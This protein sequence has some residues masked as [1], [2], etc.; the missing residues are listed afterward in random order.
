M[1]FGRNW[2]KKDSAN[3]QYTPSEV[4]TVGT[5]LSGQG[6]SMSRKTGGSK[7]GTS[8]HGNSTM[9]ILENAM[10]RR[11]EPG[12][13]GG[14]RTGPGY[15]KPR[16]RTESIVSEAFLPLAPDPESNLGGGLG[17]FG[18]LG[19]AGGPARGNTSTKHSFSVMMGA[20]KMFRGTLAGNAG[21][22]IAERDLKKA[23]EM[24]GNLTPGAGPSG[25]PKEITEA[26][27]ATEEKDQ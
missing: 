17:A 1:S 24:A 19:G 21:G 14:Q 18:Q 27:G 23:L 25:P 11:A 10:K 13:E 9:K 12:L 7:R 5:S 8:N 22:A 16:N 26:D 15:T 4:G 6:R 2:N 20:P 3:T